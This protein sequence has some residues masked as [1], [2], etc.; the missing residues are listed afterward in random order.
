MQRPALSLLA[1]LSLAVALA[2][3]GCEQKPAEPPAA[4]APAAPAAAPETAA[5]PA[6]PVAIPEGDCGDQSALPAEE[7]VANTP[8]WSTASEQDNFGFEVFRSDSENGEFVKLTASPILGAGTTDESHKYSYRDDTIDPCKEYW[9]YVE[10]ISTA[11]VRE[12]F[13]PTFKAPAKR[14]PKSTP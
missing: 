13:T 10:S 6:A 8:R 12:K 3:T 11:G 4:A 5:A 7:R 2:L 1:P 14:V 9:Y